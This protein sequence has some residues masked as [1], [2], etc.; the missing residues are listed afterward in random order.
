[1]KPIY[2]TIEKKTQQIDFYLFSLHHWGKSGPMLEIECCCT[3]LG[4]KLLECW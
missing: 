1:M 3:V 2:I 4:T